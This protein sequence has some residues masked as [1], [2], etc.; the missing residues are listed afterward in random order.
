MADTVY[1]NEKE[2]ENKHKNYFYVCKTAC[3]NTL[4][5]IT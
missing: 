2:K 3:L 4:A 5:A 1:F